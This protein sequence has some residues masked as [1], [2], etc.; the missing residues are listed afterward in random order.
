MHPGSK[1]GLA[2][3]GL[4][5]DVS[6]ALLRWMNEQ[7]QRQEASS[8]LG[9]LFHLS[10]ERYGAG[11]RGKPLVPVLRPAV[12]R[13]GSRKATRSDSAASSDL[14]SDAV[15][16]LGTARCNAN[17]VVTG[18]WEVRPCRCT[19]VCPARCILSGLL[20]ADRVLQ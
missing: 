14:K 15:L 3:L 6:P 8:Q 12:G 1:S 17:Q 2:P 18:E 16:P 7:L 10:T 20:A 4:K 9:G 11:H 13:A 19:A 5:L